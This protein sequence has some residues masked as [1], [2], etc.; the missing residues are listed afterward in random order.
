[1]NAEVRR[2]ARVHEFP[3]T[4]F[5]VVKSCQN[6]TA[7]RLSQLPGVSTSLLE[8]ILDEREVDVKKNI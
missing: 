5:T 7:F 8:D 4:F 6:S 3:P 1:M 2:N